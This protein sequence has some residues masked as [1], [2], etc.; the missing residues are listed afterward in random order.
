MKGLTI[1]ELAMKANVGVE[2]VRFYE[3]QGLIE[4]PQRP[5][6][7]FRRYPP[8]TVG[9]IRFVRRAKELGFTL[10]EISELMNLRF[11][12]HGACA[13]VR[14]IAEVK[15][16]DIETRIADLEKIRT[17]LRK[18]VT[19]CKGQG[20]ISECPILEALD[21]GVGKQGSK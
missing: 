15:V 4:Q 21:E 6:K 9:K 19:A 16:L 13:E 17:A 10:Q 5:E 2:T 7:G 12:P 20:T 3:R 8:D 1:G 14:R 18:L 11:D